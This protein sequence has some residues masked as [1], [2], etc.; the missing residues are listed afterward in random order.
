MD[1][2]WFRPRTI[3]IIALIVIAFILDQR[4]GFQ[5]A[6]SLIKITPVSAA[7][8]A[9][10]TPMA[11]GS[12]VAIFLD[13]DIVPS[14]AVVVGNDTNPSTP[15][16]ELPTLLENLSVE[17]H[18][19]SAGIFFLSARQWNILLPVDLQPGTGP[20][21]IR[22]ATG[23][24]RAVGELEVA[25]VSPAIF[26]ANTNGTGVPA[27]F[28]I[29]VL[30]SGQQRIEQAAELD[31]ASQRFAPKPI[32]LERGDE[33]VFL[34]LYLTGA[35]GIN[36]ANQ[37]RILIGGAEYIPDFVGSAPGFVGLEQINLRLPRSLPTGLLQVSFVHL[38]DG[39]AANACEIEIASPAGAPPSIRGLSR[40]EALAGEVIE[41][42]G[43]GFTP[44]SEVLISDATRKLYNA[45]LMETGSTS[46][47]V[48]VP[49][50]SGTG[51]L[52]VRNTRGEAS[53]P[54]RMRT[55]M[56]GIVQRVTAGQGGSE[57]RTGI[58]NVTIRIRQNN[59]ERTAMTN[60]DGSFLMPDVEPT[61]RLTFEVDGTT[62]GLLP[63]PKDVR[64]M[65]VVGGRDNQYEGYIELKEISGPSS[66]AGVNGVL[67]HEIVAP[68]RGRD[69]ASQ[70]STVVF[71]PQGSVARFPDGT[72]VNNI[73][74]TVLDP[75]RVPA[76]LPPAQFSSTIVQ[77]TP[78]GA[79]LDP[80]GKLT[81]PN[82][83]GYAANETVTLYRFDQVAGSST[84]GQF[85]SAG[86][87]R[88]TADG[89]RV[90]TAEN[91]I[92]ETTYYF[93]SKPRRITTIYGRVEEEI[94]GGAV[95]PA[96][97]ALVQVRGQ[98]IFSLT[99]QSGTYTLRN[100]PIPDAAV[101]SSG[102]AIEVSFLRPDGTVDRVDREGVI[103]GIAGLT[104]V[105]P[106]VRI[107][108]QGRAR[109]P[110]IQAPRSLVVEA[111]R[112][113]EFNFLAYARVAARTLTSVEVMGAEFASVTVL[114]NDRYALRLSPTAASVGVFTLELRAVDSAGE[115]TS[116][117]VLL[118]VKAAQVNTPIALSRSV[119]TNEDQ[120]VNIQL[121]GTGGSQFRVISEPRRGRLSGAVP[122]ITY[123][124]GADFTGA[125][126]FSFVVG[127]GTVESAPASVTINVQGVDDAPRLTVGDRFMTNIGQRLAIVING[128]D[129]D[130]EQK[131]TLTG[132]G[133]P[134]GALIRQVTA[135]S[136]VLEWRPTGEQI[137]IYTVNL[138]LI[139]DGMPAQSASK[140][141]TIIVDAT[142][143]PGVILSPE[144][145][146]A[147][148]LVILGDVIIVGTDG[149]GI[150]RS[151]DNGATW[152]EANTGLPPGVA[153]F[154]FSLVENGGVIFAGTNRGGVYRSLDTGATWSEANNGLVGGTARTVRAL[155]VS[156]GMIFAGTDGAGI[157]R[158]S[159]NGATWI[160]INTGLPEPARA[161]RSLTAGGGALFA[162]TNGAG[163]YR[164]PDNGATWDQAN[165]GLP[166]G[167]ARFVY[168]L[169]TS[170]VAVFAGTFA[171]G[172]YR[173]LD[174][175]MTWSEASTGLPASPRTVYALTTSGG[176]IFA[177]TNSPGVYK[178]LDNGATWSAANTGLPEGGARTA[179]ALKAAN[180]SIFAGTES[181]GVY[182]SVD[183]GTTWSAANSGLPPGAARL[184]NALT[185]SG[186]VIIAGTGSGG[187]IYRSL[188]NGVTW[189]DANTGL[190][191]GHPRTVRSLTVSGGTIFAGANAAG[192]YRSLDNGATWSE[193]NNGL[194]EG[195][196]RWVWSMTAGGGA[197]F[198]GTIGA[199]IYRSL[200]N[201]M[202]WSEANTG[203]PEGFARDVRSL[204]V[205]GGAIFA[206]NFADGIYRSLDNGATWSKSSTGVPDGRTVTA[207]T[208]SGGAIFAA[209]RGIYRSLD[210]GATWSE[211]TTGLP[212]QNARIIL[213]LTSS[214]GVIFA[215]TEGEGVFRSSAAEIQWSPVSAGLPA[216]DARVINALLASGGSIFA[217]TRGAGHYTLTESAIVWEPRSNGL[218]NLEVNT[219][220]TDGDTL[221][222]GT[223]GAGVFRTVD[224]GL[225]WISA[226]SGLPANPRVQALTRTPNN[227]I[228]GLSDAGVYFSA[229]Q[230]QSWTVRNSGLTNLRVKA[231]AND[232]ATIWVGT[233]GGVFR[234]TDQGVNWIVSNSGLTSQR[235][236]SLAVA[237]AALYAGT[238]NGMFR[239]T[240]GGGNWT[241]INTGLGN[242]YILSIGVAPDGVTVLAGT[243]NGLYR[244]TNS[245]ASW[246]LVT[247]GVADRVTPLA[248]AVAGNV[249]LMGTFSG[250]Y[251]SEDNGASWR[252][253]NTGLL[254]IQVGALAVK[255]ESVFAGTRGTG[256]FVSQLE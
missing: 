226:N 32:D 77:L 204:A 222:A 91:G 175:G 92:R 127:N 207:L 42:T 209:A 158:S 212:G 39:R 138:T 98:S 242:L 83:D 199:G 54:F 40:D 193:A 177:G 166:E 173:S 3:L 238:E 214:N 134:M 131:L 221:L 196:A 120:P 49:Y 109:A 253:R 248:F 46:L 185:L 230:G 73:T 216:G 2:Y 154:V 100:V 21:I 4:Q 102:F 53:F 106:P 111:G 15:E 232:G 118:E 217:G 174:N 252:P 224:D 231:L 64:S 97:G 33:L 63:L 99:D 137:G 69:E 72:V 125:D 184:V 249:V 6:Q 165:S 135:T 183:A 1:I 128:Y 11:P 211:A 95:Q 153:R 78:F 130:A 25:S 148:A 121:T 149:A 108:T 164:S 244:S 22:D 104:L 152:N 250:Y 254:S 116:Q 229:N 58:R 87:A 41:V 202:T 52:I 107:V 123:T 189:G 186:A 181:A 112:Q 67:A 14:G 182:R 245:G 48:M 7:S 251:V 38:A 74:A 133:L 140:S 223:F 16:V 155:A 12:I 235:V 19:R 124:P 10:Q 82:T 96:R 114:G 81:F 103:P 201:G 228:A 113:S 219:A 117:S 129:G 119:E 200:D 68:V 60:D 136:W 194:P 24:I 66:F 150:Y 29:R 31:P 75:G 169:T 227:V 28:L 146:R 70:P 23:L 240:N 160:E 210:N 61:S 176:A 147:H 236:L 190:P 13:G 115:S 208:V 180:G 237:G 139:D 157:Y 45:Q 156:N 218:S 206:G 151:F 44:D 161:L 220:I 50:G 197:I 187:G 35:Q 162:G 233:E 205:S 18:G 34:I 79:T 144:L 85:V 86:Q 93:V 37:T 122:N 203:L 90:E 159:D 110:V 26:T 234:S 171:R 80:G 59:V 94:E 225:S 215:G 191:E 56:S 43:T 62:N 76:N 170:G 30:G 9:P 55:S 239:S 198:A 51:N 195:T 213:S 27:A 84:L 8:F 247:N 71:D 255:G 47:K 256:V 17:V 126:V 192:I 163:I 167:N 132:D 101:L 179:Y 88:V 178:S 246:T 241:V 65:P 89:M 243:Q 141:I 145:A 143:T 142:W 172:V 105:T 36:D 5:A 188:D 57:E 20:I 168:A